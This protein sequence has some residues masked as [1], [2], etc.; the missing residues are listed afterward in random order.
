[1]FSVVGASIQNPVLVAL[2]GY[3]QESDRQRSHEAGSL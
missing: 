2:T 1:M 3:G